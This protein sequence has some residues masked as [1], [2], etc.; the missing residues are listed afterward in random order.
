VPV[1]W[2]SLVLNVSVFALL[3]SSAGIEEEIDPLLDPVL[4]RQF[5]KKGKRSFVT[6]S[7]KQMEVNDAFQ[8]E[9]TA[10]R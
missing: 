10:V 7:D 2:A 8:S 4:E 5:V 9:S 6:V 3:P 1:P